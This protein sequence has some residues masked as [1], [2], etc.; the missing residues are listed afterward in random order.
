MNHIR[1]EYFYFPNIPSSERQ[2]CNKLSFFIL[3]YSQALQVHHVAE[4]KVGQMT[5]LI[6]VE[7]QL[8]DAD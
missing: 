7:T 5:Y 3:R 4:E 6:I 8:L 1:S 2:F